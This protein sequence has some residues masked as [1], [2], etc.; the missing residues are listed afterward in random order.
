LVLT[1]GFL[2]IRI[3]ETEA[4]PVAMA[5]EIA[6]PLQQREYDKAMDRE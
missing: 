4:R 2:A 5:V 1:G 6:T 3:L